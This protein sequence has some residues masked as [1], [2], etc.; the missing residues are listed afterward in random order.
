MR[1]IG[2]L[3]IVLL[4]FAAN[5]QAIEPQ[6]FRWGCDTPENRFSALDI[7]FGKAVEISGSVRAKEFRPDRYLPMA[8][9][10]IES[11]DGSKSFGFQLIA[12]SEK[13][14]VLDVIFYTN[15]GSGTKRGKVGEI[16]V[17]VAHLFS[18]KISPNG[19]FSI[20]V[21]EHT[22]SGILAQV[23]TGKARLLCSSGEFEFT[24]ARFAM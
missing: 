13:P 22:L 14:K 7:T 12:E 1:L 16:A 2:M 6:S 11:E 23:E 9:G 10:K 3:G 8:G 5:A 19:S 18:L 20:T 21:G 4:P 24:E 15:D 17:D